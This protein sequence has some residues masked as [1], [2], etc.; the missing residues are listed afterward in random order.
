MG[1]PQSSDLNTDTN[2][3][4]TTGEY[5]NRGDSTDDWYHWMRVAD[6]GD[7]AQGDKDDAAVTDPTASGSVVALLKGWLTGL[8]AKADAAVTDPTSSA[9]VIAA[10]KGILTFLRVSAAGVGKAEDAAH[11]SGDTGVMALAVRRD[12]SAASSGTTGDYEPLQTDSS[13]RLRVAPDSRV[14]ALTNARTTALDNILLVKASAGTLFGFQGYA[15]LDGFIVVIADADGTISG[16]A[17]CLE[18]FPVIDPSGDGA[19]GPF[20]LDFGRYG[21]AITTGICIAFS[22]TGPTFTDGGN[23]MFVSAQYE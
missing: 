20:S 21:V 12:T 13:G 18:A 23:H 3:R 4:V 2:A 7:V 11:S 14:G 17:Q 1:S 5:G 19:G 16:G 22:T 15:D 6:G 9:S 10:L 8:G